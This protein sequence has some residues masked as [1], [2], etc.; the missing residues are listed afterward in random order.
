MIE[1]CVFT[2]VIG[3]LD[4]EREMAGG[5]SGGKRI[6][7][8]IL[9]LMY[10]ITRTRNRCLAFHVYNTNLQH[11]TKDIGISGPESTPNSS[12]SEG[13]LSYSYPLTKITRACNFIR[14]FKLISLSL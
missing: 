6:R 1:C 14:G 13:K 5:I 11:G 4:G 3:R 10:Y 8:V 7:N 2:N 9:I 12:N